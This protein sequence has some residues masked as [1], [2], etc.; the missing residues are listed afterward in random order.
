MY[1]N[2]LF[3][4]FSFGFL[5]SAAQSFNSFCANYS[6]IQQVRHPEKPEKILASLVYNGELLQKRSE[7]IYFEKPVSKEGMQK[8]IKYTGNDGNEKEYILPTATLRTIKYFNLDSGIYKFSTNVTEDIYRNTQF[9]FE[10]GFLNWQLMPETKTIGSFFVQ[11]AIII[12]NNGQ[13]GREVWFAPDIPI[14]F[15]PMGI[16]DAPGLVIEGIEN[17]I[18]VSY[19]LLSYQMDCAIEDSVFKPEP[20]NNPFIDRGILR[21]KSN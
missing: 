19:S 17:N 12:G 8:S 5:N 6:V 2:I 21:K 16:M 10:R 3:A 4:L 13:I 18:G 7:I 1:Y 15:G 20:F 14:F 9:K 11:R